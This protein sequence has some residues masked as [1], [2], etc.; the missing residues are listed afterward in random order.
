MTITGFQAPLKSMP[1]TDVEQYGLADSHLYNTTVQNISWQGITVT[2]KDRETK[3]PKAIV[4]NVE[5]Y[6]EAGQFPKTLNK[7]KGYT[8]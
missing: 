8:S 6:V 7:S 2:V 1:Y 4:D 3:Q 5:G